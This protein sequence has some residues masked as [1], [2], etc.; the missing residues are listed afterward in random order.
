[1]AAQLEGTRALITGG[2]GGIGMATARAFLEQGASVH[3]G[4]LDQSAV[5]AA[6]ALLRPLGAV[7]GS[8]VDVTDVAD[9]ARLVDDARQSMGG[10]S[11]LI[12]NAGTVA[13]APLVEMG[14]TD[15]DRQIAV[16]LKGVILCTRAVVP[17]LREA[18]NA[19]ITST[20]SQAGKRG[21]AEIAVYGATKAAV[22]G[23]SR[24][25]AIELA[26]RIRVNTICPGHIGGVGMAWRGFES[27]KPGDQTT[28]DFGQA[29]AEEFIP[30]RRLQSAEDI[31]AG[32]VFLT[33]SGAREITGAALNIG[34]GVVMD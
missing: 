21:W 7:S 9:V 12:N 10:L 13:R 14:E 8:T 25:M 11:A 4:D 30:L 1:M 27:R 22:I 23:F 24:C 31:A 26:P 5:D 20:A 6:L 28:D 34:G 29:F 3:I 33:S 15:I 32:F 19:S 17:H 18:D 2:A 16:N